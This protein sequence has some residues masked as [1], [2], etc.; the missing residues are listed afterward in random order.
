MH[1]PQ[2]RSYGFVSSKSIN[3]IQSTLGIT[4]GRHNPIPTAAKIDQRSNEPKPGQK[5]SGGNRAWQA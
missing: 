1:E 3:G 2:E 4:T 5:E